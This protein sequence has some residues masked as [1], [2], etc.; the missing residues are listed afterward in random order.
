MRKFCSILL[1]RLYACDLK[2]LYFIFK[3]L[4]RDL[5]PELGNRATPAL[6]RTFLVDSTTSN[7]VVRPPPRRL[8]R[9]PPTQAERGVPRPR[10]KKSSTSVRGQRKW[11]V[12]PLRRVRAFRPQV[13]MRR[14]Q[15]SAT[16]RNISAFRGHSMEGRT[17]T[18]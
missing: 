13:P 17:Q 10:P 1:I 18:R 12:P 6:V 3:D 7:L 16:P 9:H 15:V 5:L 11:K 14:P 4:A 2:M 8:T